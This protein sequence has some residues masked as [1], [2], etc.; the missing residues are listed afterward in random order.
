[1][2]KIFIGLS[3]LFFSICISGASNHG[4]H[5]LKQINFVKKQIRE[6]QEPYDAAYR[7]LLLMADSIQV[8]SHHALVDFSVPGFYDKPAEHRANS[9]A[10]QQD[11]FGAYCSALAYILSG[12]EKYGD[13]ACYFLNAWALTNK[14]YSGHDGVL[15]MSYS[16][17][18]FLIAAE[19][20]SDQ[21]IWKKMEQDVFRKWVKSVYQNA[22]NIIRVHKNNWADW[23][24]FGSLL[25][26]S[27][28]DDQL[29][30]SENIRL[31]KSDLELKILQDGSMPEETRRGNNGIWY[32]YF[33]LAPM[34]A[35]CWVTYNLTGENLFNWTPNGISIKMA[36]D[37]L[38]YYNAHPSDWKWS[39]NPNI[40]LKDTWPYNLIESMSGIYNDTTYMEY[41]KGRQPIVYDKH[42]FAWTFST[43]MPTRLYGYK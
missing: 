5:P 13:K 27:Y 6:R 2:K 38:A 34:T 20:M 21:K 19:L 9:L 24:R 18:A 41:V 31:I 22:T 30:V 23:G 16:G 14:G 39:S 10:L 26:A 17:S 37:S 1:M 35:A 3:V 4:M 11:A 12:E 36:L 29:E 43:I 15:V 7:K 8:V 40:G 42:H 28:L 25:A 33:S 32:T